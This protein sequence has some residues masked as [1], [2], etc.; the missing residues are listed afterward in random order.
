M[1]PRI[2]IVPGAAQFYGDV[3]MIKIAV[4]AVALA[5]SFAFAASANALTIVNKDVKNHN[6]RIMVTGAKAGD[7]PAEIKIAAGKSADF[8]CSKGCTAHLG[9]KDKGAKDAV[10]KATDKTLT[11]GANG[12]LSATAQ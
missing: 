4:I 3:P 9:K 2:G 6:V 10:I 5:T 8:D 7:K 1:V 12:D 11:I